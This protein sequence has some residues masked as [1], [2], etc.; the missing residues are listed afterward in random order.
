MKLIALAAALAVP[1]FAQEPKPDAKPDPAPTTKPEAEELKPAEL[2]PLPAPTRPNDEP[3]L[4]K[5]PPG[6]ALTPAPERPASLI[7]EG[8]APP[9]K[10][11]TLRPGMPPRGRSTLTPPTSTSELDRRIRFRQAHTRAV[12]DA[13]IQSLWADSRSAKTDYEKRAA[14]KGYY[15][16]LYRKMAALDKSIAPLIEERKV[17]AL[18]KL[19]QTRVEPTDPLDEEHRQRRD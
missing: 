1:V 3:D 17:I 16:A 19:D 5:V 11:D 15:T 7:P 8:L 10:S 9:R 4:L 18:R 14:L 2:P 12:N 13:T 6:G